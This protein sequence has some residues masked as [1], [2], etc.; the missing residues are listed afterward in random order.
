MLFHSWYLQYAND[1][2]QHFHLHFPLRHVATNRQHNTKHH[3]IGSRKQLQMERKYL[4]SAT[5]KCA[6]ARFGNDDR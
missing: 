4:A 3:Y 1:T 5:C 6:R 2:D